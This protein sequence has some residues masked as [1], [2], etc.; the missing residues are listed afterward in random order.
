MCDDAAVIFI[1]AEI[2]REYFIAFKINSLVASIDM[3]APSRKMRFMSIARRYGRHSLRAGKISAAAYAGLI[4]PMI[5]EPKF[6]THANP[7][8]QECL[9]YRYG[10]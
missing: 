5:S 10:S 9:D 3:P 7:D 2:L 4:V 8:Q 6:W 1:C